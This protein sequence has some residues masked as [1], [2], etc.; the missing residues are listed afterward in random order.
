MYPNESTGLDLCFLVNML[1]SKLE[2]DDALDLIFNSDTLKYDEVENHFLFNYN[3]VPFRFISIRNLFR[4]V[5]LFV[6][7]KDSFDGYMIDKR[8]TS[9]VK[10]L[11]GIRNSIKIPRQYRLGLES[12]Y[13]S[14]QYKKA[15]GVMGEKFVLNYEQR[16]LENHPHNNQIKCVSDEFV[17]AGFDIESFDDSNSIIIDRFIEVKTC[18]NKLEFYWSA[19]EVEV[20]RILKD[21]YFL[22]IVDCRMLDKIDY[23]PVILRNPYSTVF[24]SEEWTKEEQSWKF[25]LK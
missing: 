17:N 12:L 23:H 14:L 7:R 3:A 25:T 8:F 19:N 6:K 11:I 1:I 13:K 24:L 21:M 2:Q 10:E 9:I 5:G 22:Y 15:L 4:S 18:S 20:S 16:R